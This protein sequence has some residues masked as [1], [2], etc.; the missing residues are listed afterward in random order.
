MTGTDLRATRLRCEYLVNPLGIDVVRPRLAWA[1]ASDRR[2][3]RQI[4]Y[5]L[6]VASDLDRLLTGEGDLWDSGRVESS[7]STHVVY[8]GAEPASGQRCW[9]TVQVWNRDGLASFPSDPAWWEMGLLRPD[10]WRATWIGLD[11]GAEV[12]GRPAGDRTKPGAKRPLAELD[13]PPSPFLRRGFTLAGPVRRARLYAT[14]RGLYEL[15]L[16]GERVGD[17][18]LAPGWT[19]YAQRVQYQTYDVAPLLRSGE[20]TL[21]AI[22]G[23]GWYAGHVGW[24]GQTRHYGS[25]PRLLLRLAIDHE[26]DTTTTI[27]SDGA[28]WARTGPILASDLLMGE[29]YDARLDL[30]GWDAPGFDDRGWAPVRV[31]ARDGVRLVADRAEP[32]RVV[33]DLTPTGTSRVDPDT[34]IVDIG[35][36]M[37]G[38]VR[39]RVAGPAGTTVRLRFGEM[40]NPDGSLYTENL[41][42]A[43][44]TDAYVLRGEGTETYEP[45]FTFHG[46]RYVE[47]TGY[48][49]EL[50]PEAITGRVVESNTPEAGTFVCSNDLVN[51]LQRNILWGQR[52]NFLSIPTDCPQRDERLGWLADAQVFAPTACLNRDVAAFFTKWLGDIADARSAAGAFPDVA[53]RLIDEADGAPAW[54]DGGV[55][56]PW[57][58]YRAYGDTRLIEHH[59]DAMAGWLAYIGEANPD[60]LWRHRRGND[61]GDWLAHDAETPKELLGTAYWAHSARLLAQMGRAIGRGEDADRFDALFGEIRRAF[62]VAYVAPDGR[63]AGET[64]TGY[65]LALAMD[66]LP[67]GLRQAAGRRLV[68]DIERCDGHLSTGFA[69]V[70]S[71][72]PVLTE[73]GYPDVA[74]RILLQETLPSW[75]HMIRHGATTIWERWDGW[76]PE[77]GFQDPGMNSFNH[78]SLGSVG[79]LLYQMVAGIAVDPDRPGY[80][81]VL[82]RPRPGGGLTHAR[83]TYRSIRGPIAVA[84]EIADGAFRV[85]VTIPANSTATVFLATANPDTVTESDRPA[86]EAE[87]VRFL[88]EE[89]GCAV[90]AVGS[91]AYRFRSVTEPSGTERG[92]TAVRGSRL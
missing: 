76:T 25:S 66:L 5:R 82:V 91:G 57:T 22:L 12:A 55:V 87:G 47:V 58:L 63:V 17:A 43:H 38:W 29:T 24:F 70:A 6:L 83:A 28:W 60:H 18:V 72:L 11:V 39:L 49:G 79:A 14:A 2:G 53:P 42:S 40:L 13:L 81:H 30:P 73:A 89:E 84:W 31:D 68:A 9:W 90:F 85:D 19:D 10:D 36:N 74:Y 37:V 92:A 56:L 4:A 77:R 3:E 46:F 16:N 69:G 45:R 86:G 15:R 35:Q 59:Y 26:D 34:Q 23:T 78:Y 1:L 88:R 27:V 64:Q 50:L 32:V 21:G 80:E 48:P 41:R 7:R 75:G 62:N 54:G 65:V 51:R 20:N 33:E 8:E 61:F 52:G 44:Q 71:L 67:T